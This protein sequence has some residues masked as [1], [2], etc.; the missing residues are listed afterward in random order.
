MSDHQTTPP[1]PL[2]ID[3]FPRRSRVDHWTPIERKIA[4]AKQAVEAGPAHPFMT[5]ATILLSQAQDKVAD[6]YEIPPAPA[7]CRN[8]PTEQKPQE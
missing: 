3:G 7:V 8:P 2:L 4:E 1:K 6:Y 5:D